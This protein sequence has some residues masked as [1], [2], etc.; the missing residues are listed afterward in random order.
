MALAIGI[1]TI[2]GCYSL[3]TN[4]EHVA[5]ITLEQPVV[6]S[7]VVGDSLR[8]TLG[9][10]RAVHGAAFN[11]YDD[12]IP[13][14]PVIYRAL[15]PGLSVDSLTGAVVGDSITGTTVRIVALA[16]GLQTSAIQLL[17]IPTPDTIS[18]V[19]AEDSLLYSLRDSSVNVSVPLQVMVSHNSG[20][21][22]TPVPSYLVSYAITSTT[23]TLLAQLVGDD[24]VRGSRV[25][26]TGSDGVAGR[27]I[28][29]RPGRL[30]QPEDSVV[31]L[32]TVKYRGVAVPG[33]PVR[34]VLNVKPQP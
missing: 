14:V 5:S 15:D 6:P 33:S 23:D 11:I 9:L 24:G 30:T 25:D 13:T 2:A 28:R 26:T 34:F 27:R 31:V 21:T 16:G 7:V 1:M 18:A 22:L 3:D 29:L 17:V 10:A 20:G 12:T 32:A 8:D 4:P 19:N